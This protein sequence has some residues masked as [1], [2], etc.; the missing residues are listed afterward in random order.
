MITKE[1]LSKLTSEEKDDLIFELCEHFQKE[2]QM[3]RHE[4]Q[5]ANARIRT[6]RHDLASR[7]KSNMEWAIMT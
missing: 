1:Q 5:Q 2:L 4:L 6:C 3:L 7:F